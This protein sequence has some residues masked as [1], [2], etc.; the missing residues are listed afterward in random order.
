MLLSKKI[1]LSESWT[2]ASGVE[3][4]DVTPMTTSCWMSNRNGSVT[5]SPSTVRCVMVLSAPMHSAR[6]IWKDRMPSN[7]GI[8][9]RC[10]VLDESHPPT[11]RIKSKPSCLAISTSSVTAS[12]RSC[13]A[14]G[15]KDRKSQTKS[16]DCYEHLW[17]KEYNARTCV[18]SQM[19]SNSM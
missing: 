5:I 6:L 1:W 9:N 18:A 4:P 8:S 11:T 10:A 13:C 16:I 14:K 12:C 7:W 15:L 17:S 19:V 2:A 3:A